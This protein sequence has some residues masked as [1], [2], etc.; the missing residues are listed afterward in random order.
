LRLLLDTN[1]FLRWRVGRPVPR[2]VERVLKRRGTESFV[3]IVTAWEIALKHSLHVSMA[4]FQTSIAAMEATM[5]PITFGHL[6]EF[7]RL[8]GYTNHRDPFDRMLI[9][10]AISED[11][12][13]VSS[14]TRFTSYKRLRVLWD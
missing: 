5:L 8:P 9:A 6:D 4:D 11:L 1:A 14:D 3:S 2:P 10:Q 13:I 7:A 12:T